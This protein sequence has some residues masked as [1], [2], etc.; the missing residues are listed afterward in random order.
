MKSIIISVLFLLCYCE[1]DAQIYSNQPKYFP[2]GTF[3]VWSTKD[4][5]SEHLSFEISRFSIK[6]SK[7]FNQK[8]YYCVEKISS[9]I[10]EEECYIREEDE[11]VFAYYPS[12][13]KE[14]LYY[15]FN[16]MDG[17]GCALIDIYERSYLSIRT[18]DVQSVILTDGVEYAMTQSY[19]IIRTIGKTYDSSLFSLFPDGVLDNGARCFVSSFVRNGVELLHKNNY[20]GIREVNETHFGQLNKNTSAYIDLL[21]RQ[22]K[23]LPRKGVYIRDGRKV[24]VK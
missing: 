22:L 24:V 18:E 4:F 13:D 10:V 14:V 16:W 23:E 15:N 8:E 6:G 12:L 17:E 19:G 5:G 21:G 20:V 11:K 7:I 2:Q 9:G 3:W 1:I